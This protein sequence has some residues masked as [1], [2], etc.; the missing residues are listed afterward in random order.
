MENFKITADSSCDL[1]S[2]TISKYNIDITPIYVSIDGGTTFL[3]D[4]LE[5]D[6]DEF[7]KK[8]EDKDFFPKTSLAP[9][10]DY[11]EVFEKY[12][13]DGI[14]VLHLSI[15]SKLSGSHQSA[16]NASQILKEKYSDRN[17]VVIDTE[18]VTVGQGLV[19]QEACRLREM[20]FSI[21]DTQTIINKIK[22]DIKIA[23]TVGSIEY[24]IRGGRIGKASGFAGNLLNIRP[25]LAFVDAEI[26]SIAKVRGSKKLLQEIINTFEKDIDYKNN[27]YKVRAVKSSEKTDYNELIKMLKDKNI[28]VETE[29][30]K[31][32][33]LV[34]SHVG[35]S[36]FGVGYMPVLT[37]EQLKNM[38]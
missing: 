17:I 26:T 27:N 29:I 25:V 12:L 18:N 24:L 16:V 14:D 33:A 9:V 22:K 19:V 13:K 28:E 35:A 20:N 31:A 34:V 4:G 38:L 36:A 8:L 37:E 7:Y 6:V 10:Q 11:L 21:L 30:M 15:S 23:F 5:I 3:K 2:H 1:P 32:G